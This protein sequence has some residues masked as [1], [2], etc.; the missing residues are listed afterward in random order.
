MLI[1]LGGSFGMDPERFD[2]AK[3]ILIWGSNPLSRTFICVARAGGEASR[4]EARRDRPYRSLSAEK[5]HEHLAC[6]PAPMRRSRSDDARH[7]RREPLRCG[8]RAQIYDRSRRS[9]GAWRN[10]RRAKSRRS[11][12]CP[13]KKYRARREYAATRPAA[14]RLNYGLQRTRA[15]HGVRNI[16]C[17][18]ALTGAW[19]DPAGGRC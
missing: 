10:T 8:L 18:P 19:R 13:P 16:L 12:A 14:I 4:R 9:P 1:T 15:G 5:C 7:Y 3:L 2:E 17:L 6:C 11:P